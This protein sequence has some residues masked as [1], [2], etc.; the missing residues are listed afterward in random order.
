MGKNIDCLFIG[1]NEMDFEEYERSI[2]KMGY[3]SGAYRDLNLN[4][5]RYK[6]KPRTLPEIFNLFY[7]NNGGVHSRES[8]N[9]LRMGET[10]SAAISYLGSYLHRRGFTFDLV[11]AFQ[12]EKAELAEK[13][14]SQHVLAVAIIT[15]YYVFALPIF[16]I[17]EFVK[18]HNP[19]TK[20]IIGGPFI[21][22]QYRTQAPTV[23]E[24]LFESINADFYVI[25][26]QGEAT[27]VKLLH[28]IKSDFSYESIENIYYKTGKGYQSTQVVREDNQ[29]SAERVNWSLF[30]GKVGE[31][32]DVR[33]VISCP[34]SCAFCGS[35]EHSGK[36]QTL[37]D[38]EIESELNQLV[39]IESLKGLS[40]IDDT[41]NVPAQRFKNILRMMKKNNYQ[42]EWISNLRCQFADREMVELMK[43]CGCQG[44]FLGIESGNDQ[45]L[46]NMNKA[47]SVEKYLNGISLLKEY[48]I[49]T[50]GSFILGFPGE[51]CD[52]VQDTLRFI[53]ESGLD[54]FRPHLFYFEPITPIWKERVKYDLKGESFEW[55]HRTMDSKTA[56]DL[57]DKIFLSVKNTIWVPQYN[58]DFDHLWRLRHRGMSLEQ[59]KEFLNAFNNAI[60]EKLV[61]PS[62]EAISP[63][64]I[65]RI[66]KACQGNSETDN[67]P[68][69]HL[70]LAE[71]Y[72]VNFNF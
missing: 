27:L 61:N 37:S 3:N 59:I 32:V 30:S 8:I 16:E 31:Y 21:F 39:E 42:F 57:I 47:A 49:L 34:F 67:S 33:T 11:N 15:T 44:V 19:D 56:A 4:F 7:F 63:E 50:F 14:T 13:L 5:I 23:Y 46:K 41:F 36:Y 48:G 52:T 9:P 18:K 68:D 64:A 72:E 28:A 6:N 62:Q 55:I 43:E 45:I 12:Y 66:K 35:P 10:F 38:R 51:T 24:C 17:V 2:S 58:F 20:I 69:E 70:P 53:E 60:R 26:H 40:F 65:Q 1:H 25:S 22:S 29:L 71:S 54:F